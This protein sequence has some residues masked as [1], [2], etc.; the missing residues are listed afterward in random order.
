MD[1]AERDANARL[2]AAAPTMLEALKALVD[3]PLRYNGNMI[4]IECNSHGAAMAL[5]KSARAAIALAEG[6]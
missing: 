1:R 5:V 3:K 2:I 4:E 6:E